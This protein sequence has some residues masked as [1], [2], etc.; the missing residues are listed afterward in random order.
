MGRFNGWMKMG[1]A[2]VKTREYEHYYFLR[3]RVLRSYVWGSFLHAS[4][5]TYVMRSQRKHSGAFSLLHVCLAVLEQALPDERLAEQKF[6]VFFC[7]ALSWQ[8]LQEHHDLLE[9]HLA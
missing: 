7:P 2:A 4:C 9:V 5:H 6:D 3:S 8:S 1:I